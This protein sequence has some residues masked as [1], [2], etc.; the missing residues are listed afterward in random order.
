M[1][2]YKVTFENNKA[3]NAVPANDLAHC[4]MEFDESNSTVYWLALEC[5][6]KDTAIKIADFVARVMWRQQ[7]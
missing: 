1:N 3:I 6:D 2:M 7:H 4:D 5:E